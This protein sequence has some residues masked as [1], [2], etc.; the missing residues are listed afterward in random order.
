MP[1]TEKATL[2]TAEIADFLATC[3]SRDELLNYRPSKAV[4]NR[5]RELLRKNSDGKITKF[6]EWELDQYE[7]AEMLLGLVKARL[8][9]EK[10]PK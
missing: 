2:L 6:E 3:P 4:Q 10:A 1:V 9:S 5:A 8:R 7:F